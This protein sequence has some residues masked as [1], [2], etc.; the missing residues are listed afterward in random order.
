MIEVK[1]RT[2]PHY[3]KS[4]FTAIMLCCFLGMF[5]IHRFYTGYKRIGFIQMFTLGGFFIWWFIDLISM[6]FKSYKD[7]YGI[8]LEEYNGTLASFVLLG[9]A[10]VLL[11][12][13][14]LSLPM[15]FEKM[16]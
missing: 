14:S 4:F 3:P 8:E 16:I 12:L 7:K 13:G 10:L 9:F 15:L 2:T 5:G 11:V 6:C 1:K